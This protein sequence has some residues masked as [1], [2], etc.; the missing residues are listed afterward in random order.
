MGLRPPRF[1]LASLVACISFTASA[2]AAGTGTLSGKLADGKLPSAANGRAYV[3]AIHLPDGQIEGAIAAGRSGAWKLPLGAGSYVVTASVV[4]LDKK[5]VSAIAPVQS[6]RTGRTTRTRVSLKR[7][8]TP[9]IKRP[10]RRGARA[11]ATASAPVGVLSFTGTGPNAQ[12][13]PGLAQ[14]LTTELVNTSSGNCEPTV[15][16]MMRRADVLREIALANSGLTDPSSRIPTGNLI[17]PAYLIK[18][19]VNTTATTTSWN[20]SLV[21]ANS[22]AQV[23]AD[24]GTAN[25]ADVFDA[26][27]GIAQR[28]ADQLCGSDYQV[29]IDLNAMVVAD[30]L[31]GTGLVKAIIP[32]H[33]LPGTE[34][35]TTWMGQTNI[36]VVPSYSGGPP[37]CVVAATPLIGYLKVDINKSRTPGLIEV[38][39]SGTASGT[40]DFTCTA[41]DGTVLALPG[42]APPLLPFAGT[43]PTL[44]ILPE[45][46][47]SQSLSGGGGGLINNGTITV[48]R[49]PRGTL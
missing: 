6:V 5:V 19:T 34:P 39:W 41:D 23:G 30:T 35:P 11:A 27:S 4:R 40:A 16:E 46:G 49:L 3:S 36:T 43:A 26:A 31:V 1:A 37:Q 47:G 15:I 17:D 18:G 21:D 42:S 28:L 14:M 25:G 38:I 33:A 24:S 12:L 44:V 8:K 2:A 32:T 20:L 29:I 22:G 48:T 7:T 10:R 45:T 13:G 9:R